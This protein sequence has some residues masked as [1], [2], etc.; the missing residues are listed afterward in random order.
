MKIKSI[1][2]AW[3]SWTRLWPISRKYYP[4]QFIKIKELWDI[5]L[6]QQTIL[7]ASKLSSLSD[8]FITSNSSYK[9][10]A[11]TQAH[12]VW[13]K[14][15]EDQILI[16]PIAK[17]TL[18]A[19]AYAMNNLEKWDLWLILPSDHI[20]W[21]EEVFIKTIIDASETAT[22]WLVTFGITP[23]C[24]HTWYWYIDVDKKTKAPY[25]VKSFKEK[26]DEITAKQFIKDWYFWNA[27]IFL[28][29]KEIFFSE[30]HKNNKEF[31]E[32]FTSEKDVK[33]LFDKIPELSIDYWLLEKSDNIYLAPLPIYW[34]D[35]WSFDAIDDYLASKNYNNP[36]V[37]QIDW[38]NNFILSETDN[39]KVAIIW[40]D[41]LIVVDTKDALLISK[42]WK[43]Q[44]IKD[45]VSLLKKDNSTLAEYWVTVYRPWG[46]YT[47]IDEG[48][49]FKSKR[50][51]VISGKKLSLQMHY[52]R[53]E[54][55]VVVSWTAVVTVWE[56]VKT[57]RKWESVYI[58][59]GFKHRLENPWKLELHL[60]ESQIWDY[61]EEDDIVRF[62]DDF[63]RN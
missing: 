10:N 47:I 31:Y 57:V 21:D 12:E 34:N 3:W 24:P 60:I 26:P 63:G 15:K 52:H 11:L 5:S 9:F 28:F 51:T 43:T 18:P 35:L 44:K 59:A 13:V 17:N 1:V 16:E 56:E 55:W 14:I 53:S 6:F 29:S 41:D 40:L 27:W 48:P 4:K 30:L 20:I 22:K 54:H 32:I 62:D 61:L 50:I 2:M 23:F 46:S 25:K 58:P 37:M 19:I 36:D 45:I 7:R 39:K 8:I 49:G 42:K 38:K 33:T